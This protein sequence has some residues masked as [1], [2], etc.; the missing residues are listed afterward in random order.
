MQAQAQNPPP[1][2]LRPIQ[3][4]MQARMGWLKAMFQNLEAKNLAAVGK[5][6]GE[7]SAQTAKAAAGL[8]GERKELSQKV[9]DLAKAAS[10]AAGKGDA[11]ALQAR[12]G[13]IK[14]TCAACHDKYRDR[15]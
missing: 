15:K 13:D 6:A 10:E 14:A 9:S 5:D 3:K 12:L 4:V 7:L 11:D 2:E 8:E 1:A